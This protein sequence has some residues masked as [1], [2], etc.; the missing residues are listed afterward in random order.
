MSEDESNDE[1]DMYDEEYDSEVS[2]EETN[3][4]TNR[5]DENIPLF[6]RLKVLEEEK[7]LRSYENKPN[8]KPKKHFEKKTDNDGKKDKNSPAIISSRRQVP[9]LRA[10]SLAKT[11]KHED[12]RFSE[13]NG[14]LNY[15]KFTSNYAF[16]DENQQQEVGLLEK[17]MKKAKSSE[18]RETLKAELSK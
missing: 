3:M 6:E 9:I 4:K 17:R 14:K 11:Q 2:E 1:S 15:D 12:P 5:N 13:A 7:Q 8:I 18:K 16:L 10:S